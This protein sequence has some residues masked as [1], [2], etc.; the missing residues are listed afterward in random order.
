M[1]ASVGLRKTTD[2][3]SKDPGSTLSPETLLPLES[4]SPPPP[5]L[6]VQNVLATISRPFSGLPSVWIFAP[7][8]PAS[9]S[10]QRVSYDPTPTNLRYFVPVCNMCICWISERSSWVYP[11]VVQY[12]PR[13]AHP[14]GLRPLPCYPAFMAMEAM[15][16]P[17]L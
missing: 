1:R 13:S 7:A 9:A 6:Q 5:S 4:I 3:P 2:P 15:T 8:R 12:V 11:T 16:P 10:L 17:T 14:A